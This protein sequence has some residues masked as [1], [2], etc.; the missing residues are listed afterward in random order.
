MLWY[1]G[2]RYRAIMALLLFLLFLH[3]H[4]S[5][6]SSTSSSL[7]DFWL[8]FRYRSNNH[9]SGPP[10]WLAAPMADLQVYLSW[11]SN[12]RE[13][14]LSTISTIPLCRLLPCHLGPPRHMLSLNLYVKGCLDCTIGAFHMSI[15]SEPSLLQ[16]EVQILSARPCK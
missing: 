11:G 1:S 5:S 16:N 9:I 13:L 3:C 2:E 12:S 6:S 15:P 8:M 7:T 10:S 4:S 14:S